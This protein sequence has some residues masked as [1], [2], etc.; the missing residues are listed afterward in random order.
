MLGISES[1]VKRHVEN[2]LVTPVKDERG[3][4]LYPIDK[5]EEIRESIE[6][7]R[8]RRMASSPTGT[9][10]AGSAVAPEIFVTVLEHLD[11]GKH[12]VDIAKL[13]GL[14][15]AQLDP[16]HR[17]WV[18]K[19]Q[20][21]L[22]TADMAEEIHGLLGV[23]AKNMSESRALKSS[24]RSVIELLDLLTNKM[25]ILE[26]DAPDKGKCSGCRAAKATLCR[27]CAQKRFKAKD[28][29]AE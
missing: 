24:P 28:V 8:V 26:S 12:I 11:A 2:Q 5:V 20:G 4:H 25:R 1:S 21:Y 15:P 7:T 22:V 18:D 19:R 10:P 3:R 9:A 16:I 13:M 27:A 17:W 29:D 6:I 14:L 23:Y